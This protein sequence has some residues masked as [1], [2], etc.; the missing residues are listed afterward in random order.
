MKNITLAVE[1]E[2]VDEARV[3]AAERKTTVNA[4]V[5]DFLRTAVA[6]RRLLSDLSDGTA[7]DREIVSTPDTPITAHERMARIFAEGQAKYADRKLVDREYIYDRDYQR[8]E[9]YFENR[10]AL[11]KLIDETTA[12][13]GKQ[14][15][16]REA[17][18][19]R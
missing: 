1:D 4:M 2:I 10:N 8:A 17:L 13:M 15:W 14:K 7:E 9:L 3:L 5:R 6:K 11:L 12:D 19:D 16:N 18:Y